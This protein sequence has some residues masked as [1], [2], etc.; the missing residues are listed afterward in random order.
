M[1]RYHCSTKM[2]YI[3]GTTIAI[4]HDFAHGQRTDKIGQYGI[5]LLLIDPWILSI[6][7]QLPICAHKQQCI[8]SN[9]FLLSFLLCVSNWVAV[10]SLL[11]ILL[12]SSTG[13]I[14]FGILSKKYLSTADWNTELKMHSGLKFQLVATL[15]IPQTILSEYM[16]YWYI[17]FN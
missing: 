8:I 6:Y 10:W 1:I 9:E 5:R 7:V 15:V 3:F 17:P 16:S 12:W 14:R 4:T 13:K 11:E 2:S